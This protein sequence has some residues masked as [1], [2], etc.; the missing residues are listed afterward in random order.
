MSYESLDLNVAQGVAHITLNQPEAG[1]PINDVFCDEWLQLANELASRHDVRAILVK[2]RGKYFSLGGDID[3]FS[4]NLDHLPELVIRCTAALHMGMARFFRIDAPIVAA[5]HATVIGGGVGLIAGCD[6]VYSASSAVFGSAYSKIGYCADM[7]ASYALASRM[8]QARA[9][10][11]LLLGETLTAEEAMRTGLV[12][13]MV[14]DSAL[15]VEAEAA[16][17][18]LA[19][20]PTRAYGEI[21]K[22][23][24]TALSQ[25]YEAQLEDEAQAMAKLAGSA[26]V[27]EAITA[28]TEKRKPLFQGK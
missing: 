16:A 12:D 5:V 1:N 17:I 6:L 10:R 7:G 13:F 18:R 28:F 27:R 14:E 2:A 11:Y 15:Q 19:N 25:G 9:R 21:R 22:L 3:M 8:G 4:R 26:D 24:R 20:G 23:L